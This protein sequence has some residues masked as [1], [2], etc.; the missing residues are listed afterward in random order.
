LSK[1]CRVRTLVQQTQPAGRYEVQW[2]GR[3]ERGEHVS[4][5]VYLYQ[6]RAGDF[7]QARLMALVR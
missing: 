2:D 1:G 7:V 3:N 6:L 4:S 5:G